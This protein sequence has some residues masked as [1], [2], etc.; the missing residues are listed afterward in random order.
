MR[1]P[2]LIAADFRS[3][4]SAITNFSL[5]MRGVLDVEDLTMPIP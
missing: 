3:A 4:N 1:C 5:L 2:V